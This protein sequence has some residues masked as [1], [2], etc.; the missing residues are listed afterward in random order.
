MIN[1]F[2]V[3]LA[4]AGMEAIAHFAHKYIMH[5]FLWSLHKSHHQKGRTFFE[6]NDW[7]FLIFATPGIALLFLGISNDFNWMFFI[8]LGISLYG[9]TYL[10]VHDVIIHQRIKWLKRLDNSYIRALRRA[11]KDHHAETDKNAARSYGMLWI[12]RKYF[13]SSAR[14]DKVRVYSQI[15][16]FCERDY[17]F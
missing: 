4:F 2:L 6:R 14:L 1:I 8:G 15:R 12:D 7:Y 13:A 16:F 5:G 3:L 11:H 10:V 9:M 17:P